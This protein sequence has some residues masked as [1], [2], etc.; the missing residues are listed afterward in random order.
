MQSQQ[1]SLIKEIE[2]TVYLLMGYIH[3]FDAQKPYH[4]IYCLCRGPRHSAFP[5]SIGIAK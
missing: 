3:T 1:I 5:E 2:G 4:G